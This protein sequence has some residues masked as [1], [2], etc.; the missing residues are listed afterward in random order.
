MSLLCLA[1]P[2]S[3]H[4]YLDKVPPIP[5]TV[6]RVR[7]VLWVRLVGPQEELATSAHDNLGYNNNSDVYA[8]L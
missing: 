8:P 6:V 2:N 3:N 5:T 7:A 4:R 1:N